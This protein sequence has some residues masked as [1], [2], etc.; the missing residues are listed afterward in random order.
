MLNLRN[1]ITGVAYVHEIGLVE[2][3]CGLMF[4]FAAVVKDPRQHDYK[5]WSAWDFQVLLP[6]GVENTELDGDCSNAKASSY[7]H[8]SFLDIDKQRLYSR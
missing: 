4:C 8:N 6:I 3:F 7:L 5:E 1:L 2:S